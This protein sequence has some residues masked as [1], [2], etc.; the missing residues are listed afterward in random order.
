[1][2]IKGR[3][4]C[5]YLGFSVDVGYEEVVDYGVQLVFEPYLMVILQSLEFPFFF[6]LRQLS[7][8][9]RFYVYL[10]LIGHP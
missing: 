2:S 5:P 6:L 9:I 1:M 7:R 3:A 8:L 4:V 10:R